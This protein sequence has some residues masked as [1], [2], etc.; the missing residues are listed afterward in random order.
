MVLGQDMQLW[1]GSMRINSGGLYLGGSNALYDDSG[2]NWGDDTVALGQGVRTTDDVTFAALTVDPNGTSN[3]INANGSNDASLS[4][5]SAAAYGTPLGSL[6]SDGSAGFLGGAV[7]IGV[8]S[9]ESDG[10]SVSDYS[11]NPTS[12]INRDGSASF[13]SGSCLI[14]AAAGSGTFGN[15][16]AVISNADGTGSSF[17]NGI[18]VIDEVGNLIVNN[19]GAIDV[20]GNIYNNTGTSI[21]LDGSIIITT[22][23]TQLYPD[24]SASFAG[25]LAGF[26]AYGNLTAANFSDG[27]GGNPFDQ[28]LNT[29]DD[30]SFS[31]IECGSINGNGILTT[32]YVQAYSISAVS[33]DVPPNAAEGTMYWN[34]TTHAL[35]V[36]DGSAWKTVTL[37]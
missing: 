20:T 4:W 27:G 28:N 29:S 34:T 30:V 37:T 31:S 35:K 19:N 8:G 36:Y 12:K 3:L 33:S 11:F 25:G 16:D 22:G 24:G 2:L 14:D 21:N 9:A 1:N 23:V 10:I 13:A 17:A 32:G 6:N 18:V 7:T 26:D 15:G 5:G